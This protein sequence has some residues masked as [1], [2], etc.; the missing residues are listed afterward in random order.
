MARK[1]QLIIVKFII[2]I[3]ENV[4]NDRIKEC[5]CIGKSDKQL[6]KRGSNDNRGYN[7]IKI[8][9]AKCHFE[10]KVH[11]YMRRLESM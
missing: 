9:S 1:I 7:S 10:I 2:L 6:T 8:P 5:V 4:T 3:I 11:E